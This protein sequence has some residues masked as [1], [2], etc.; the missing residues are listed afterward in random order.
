MSQRRE[1]DNP[2]NR[3]KEPVK[4][5]LCGWVGAVMQTHIFRLMSHLSNSASSIYGRTKYL[6]VGRVAHQA[7]T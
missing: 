1:D 4:G 7:T 6:E 2:I 5:L 3:F